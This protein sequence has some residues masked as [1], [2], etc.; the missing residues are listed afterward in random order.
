MIINFR[1]AAVAK[2]SVVIAGKILSQFKHKFSLEMRI[3]NLGEKGSLNL[4][5][6]NIMSTIWLD[7]SKGEK[8][9]GA[10]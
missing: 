3:C 8:P 5:Q 7:S 4:F 2:Q 1:K 10:I 9:I 6:A